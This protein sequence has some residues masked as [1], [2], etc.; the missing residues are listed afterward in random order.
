MFTRGALSRPG[1]VGM[2]RCHLHVVCV[3]SSK[4]ERVGHDV[5]RLDE[6]LLTLAAMM[7][8]GD[9]TGALE[10]YIA[11]DAELARYVK[12]EERLLFPVLER[13]TSIPVG[14]TTIMREEH[15]SMRRLLDSLGVAL[16]MPDQR[17][18]LEL[19][20]L[21]RSVLMVHVLKEDGLL[22]PL[23]RCELHAH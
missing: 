20:A 2:P 9:W 22:K 15:R 7:R 17:R 16:R 18:G 8:S 12:G 1:R 5:G 13:F 4:E 21:L 11:F 3:S 14:A 10:Q 6:T 19:V 23:L